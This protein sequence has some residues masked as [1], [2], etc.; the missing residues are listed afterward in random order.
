MFL[1]WLVCWLAGLLARLLRK[2][3]T[4]FGSIFERDRPALGQEKVG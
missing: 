3:R 1:P 2:L 4:N